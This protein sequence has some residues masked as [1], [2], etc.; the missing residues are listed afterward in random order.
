MYDPKLLING[1]LADDGRYEQDAEDW[2][3]DKIEAPGW[4]TANNPE[5]RLFLQ[6][7]IEHAS[8]DAIGYERLSIVEY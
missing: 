6:V 7:W 8:R 5:K 1:I 4:F 2:S 3:Y